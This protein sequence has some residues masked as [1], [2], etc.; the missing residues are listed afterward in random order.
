MLPVTA[1]LLNN[2]HRLRY[3]I[4]SANTSLG[5]TH[6]IYDVDGILI[7]VFKNNE[8][9]GVAYPK[10]QPMKIYSSLCE[11]DYWAT[12]AGR[13]KTDWTNAPFSASYRSFNDVDCCSWTSVWNWV[14]YDANSNSWMWTTLNSNQLGQMKCVQDDYM[15]Y[16]YCDDFKSFPQDKNRMPTSNPRNAT[17]ADRVAGKFNLV[18]FLSF[19]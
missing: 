2:R 19:F 18:Q 12:Q 13:V 1:T 16:N 17:S 15:I 5:K 9:H 14:T 3:L 6:H 8:A 4:W 11:A 10:S 7:R